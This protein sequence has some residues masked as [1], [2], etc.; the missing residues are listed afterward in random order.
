MGGCSAK[1]A[2]VPAS[3]PASSASTNV[4]HSG[5]PKVDHPLPASVLSGDP[6]QSA[7]TSDQL[8]Q[9]LGTVPQ[10]KP[11]SIDG[12]GPSCD[13]HADASVSVSYVTQDHQGL[14]AVYRN[15]K[16]QT[17]VWRVFPLIQGFP[18]VG[19][20]SKESKLGDI[21]TVSVGIA[22]N[23]SFDAGLILSRARKEAHAD[24]CELA[25]RVAGMV[26]T[27]LRQKA[28]S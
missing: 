6:C 5:A 11:D 25:A 15:A 2:A 20:V 26:A 17:S 28:G 1:P 23:V 9:I 19:Y 3:A 7:L 22:D 21:C 24:P 12:L 27:N 14:S 4:P 18:A 13:W 8:A 10:G 16:P